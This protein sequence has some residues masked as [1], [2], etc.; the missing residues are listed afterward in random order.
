MRMVRGLAGMASMAGSLD[1]TLPSVMAARRLWTGE[2][3]ALPAVGV[4]LGM[5]AAIIGVGL[6]LT[7]M[8]GRQILWGSLASSAM[9]EAYVLAWTYNQVT[10]G[11]MAAPQ[12]VPAPEPPV[13]IAGLHGGLR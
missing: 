13:T 1:P 5:R 11:K 7:G 2:K 8:R 4:S 6:S 10:A 12:P 9:I 3:N